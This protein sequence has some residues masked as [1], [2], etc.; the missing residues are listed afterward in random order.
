MQTWYKGT[1][2]KL[3]AVLL[4]GVLNGCA[5]L[6]NP[7]ADA[8]PVHR[9]PPELLGKP[10]HLRREGF[11]SVGGLAHRSMGIAGVDALDDAR[12]LPMGE[13]DVE[14]DAGEITA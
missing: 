14:V 2:G 12:E 11:E 6:T 9:T 7:V 1:P 5:A 13:R 10:H 8:L 4:C 3:A